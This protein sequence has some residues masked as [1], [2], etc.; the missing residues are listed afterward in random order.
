MIFAPME[1]IRY[2][3]VVTPAKALEEQNKRYRRHHPF[4]K[5]LFRRQCLILTQPP[6]VVM[7]ARRTPAITER[8]CNKRQRTVAFPSI[9]PRLVE[10]D[11]RINATAKLPDERM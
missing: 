2:D 6:G 1:Q 10:P 8:R 9:S 4:G 5:T 7:Y 11:C 3:C